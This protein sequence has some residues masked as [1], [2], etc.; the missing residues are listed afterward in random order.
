MKTFENFLTKLNQIELK[1][2]MNVQNHS[3]NIFQNNSNS[4]YN[5]NNFI[6]N[7]DSF[8]TEWFA[9]LSKSNTTTQMYDEYSFLRNIE[10]NKFALKILSITSQ[11]NFKLE[12]SL[13][14]GITF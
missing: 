13:T 1:W 7:S 2:F 6:L 3:K 9:L 8:L 12:T 4:N 5:Y 14:M 11:F 10:L